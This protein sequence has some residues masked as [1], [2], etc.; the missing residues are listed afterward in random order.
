MSVST[1][2]S[3][4]CGRSARLLWPAG[5]MLVLPARRRRMPALPRLRQESRSGAVAM[6]LLRTAFDCHGGCCGSGTWLV[7][8][9]MPS[10][11]KSRFG[12]SLACW[13]NGAA[14]SARGCGW[15]ASLQA[16][17]GSRHAGQNA[18]CLRLEGMGL[19]RAREARSAGHPA[20]DAARGQG[21]CG[22]GPAAAR[23]QPRRQRERERAAHRAGA[24]PAAVAAAPQQHAGEDRQEPRGARPGA[25]SL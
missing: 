18:W 1:V 8:V 2:L 3:S 25:A 13:T 6:L 9:L 5:C 15:I 22:R 24:G 4:R 16:R 7:C 10:A 20:P 14:R 19:T 23:H 17:T 12:S 11:W 21:V